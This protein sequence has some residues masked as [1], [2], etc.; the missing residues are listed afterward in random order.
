MGNI[1]AYVAGNLVDKTG[2]LFAWFTRPKNIKNALVTALTVLIASQLFVF[3]VLIAA[4]VNT[5]DSW[6]EAFKSLNCSGCG[7]LFL[8]EM[9]I[10]AL[11]LFLVKYKVIVLILSA[12]ILAGGI[13]LIRAIPDE[14]YEIGDI[15]AILLLLSAPAVI[16]GLAGFEILP[17]LINNYIR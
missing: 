7:F 14:W 12:L 2:K 1:A 3:Y 8:W 5:A 11:G 4:R 6:L 16:I 10:N 13:F 15:P 17:Y 9:L